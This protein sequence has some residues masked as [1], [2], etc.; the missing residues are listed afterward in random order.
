[1]SLSWLPA[2]GSTAYD[3]YFGADA[4]N[5]ALLGQVTDTAYSDDA[6]ALVSETVY[7]WRVDAVTADGVVTGPTWS[8][9]TRPVFPVE[10][11]LAGWYKFELGQGTTVIDWARRGND[12]FIVGDPQWVSSG[13]AGNALSFDGDG[14]YVQ[15]PRVV[16]DDWTIMLWLRTDDLAQGGGGNRF[17]TATSALIDGDFGSQLENFALTFKSGSILAGCT[18]PGVGA[19]AALIS[20][21]TIEDTE[22]HSVAWTR[23]AETGEMALYMDGTLDVSA[24]RDDDAWK[25]TK[26]AQDHIKIGLHDYSNNQGFWNG[27]LDEIKFFTRVLDEPEIQDE[28]RPDKRQASQPSPYSGQNVDRETVVTLSWRAGEGATAHNV[29]VGTDPQNLTLAGTA[30]TDASYEIGLLSRGTHY[31]QIGEI[32]PDTKE[33]LSQIWRIEVIEYL[34]V[35][36]FETYGQTQDDNPVWDT[37]MDGFATGESGSQAGDS[38]EP[39]VEITTVYEGQQALPLLYDNTSFS[40]YAPGAKH[41]EIYRI[42]EGGI[43]FTRYGS[44]TLR[45]WF[46]GGEN[47]VVFDTDVVY[48][49]FQDTSGAVAVVPYVTPEGAQIPP[50]QDP[51]WQ[52]MSVDLTA[53]TGVDLTAVERFYVGIGD[54]NNPVAGSIGRIIVDEIRL[55]P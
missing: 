40:S 49:A 26:D 5:L 30:A 53:I 16:E 54:R 13:F 4:E 47:N 9:T 14:D 19:A 34:I 29:Y 12:G 35:D 50:L 41:S 1:M 36:N 10:D 43:D 2:F 37:W 33:I 45:L 31:W 18:M 51:R 25:G 52:E 3:V 8:F 48:V 11:A 27:E 39:F 22:W 44:T 28:M 15:I 21:R 42:Y 23:N 46:Y 38:L 7:Y 24:S 17:R 32:M 6:Q 20:D 55:Y